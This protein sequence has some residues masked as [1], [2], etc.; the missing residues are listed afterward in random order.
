MRKWIVY[1]V[2]AALIL[3]GGGWLIMQRQPASSAGSDQPTETAVVQRGALAVTVE[4][5]GSLLPSTEITLAFPMG[6]KV[7]KVLV[8][9]G[10]MVEAGDLLVRLDDAALRK[11]LE[12]AELDLQSLTSPYAIADA[13]KAL[14]SAQDALEDAK[15]TNRVQQEG[16]RG[17]ASTIDGLKAELILANDNVEKKQ[18][19]FDHFADRDKDDYQRA[20]AQ[21]DL[22]AAIDARDAILRQLNWYLGHPSELDQAI[23]DADVAVAEAKVAAAKTLLAELN[24]E[25]V[26]QDE[27]LYLD[28]ALTRLQEAK[29]SVDNAKLAIADA[30]LVAPSGG[31]I[32]SL[33]VG[34]G[35]Y[36][37]PGQPVIVLSEVDDLQ[38]EINLDETD[39]ARIAIGS[40]VAITID[41]F[42]GAEL[43]GEVID[44][45]PS[46]TVQS[47]VVLYP[48]TVR[49]DPTDPS[50]GSGQALPLRPG[51]TANVTI[52]VEKREN[53]LFVP[54]RA[55]E[56][57][58]GQAYVTLKTE[59]GNLRVPVTLGLITDTQIEILSGVSEG[60]VVAVY[61][62]P[63]QD[64]SLQMQSPF[65][66]GQ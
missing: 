32:S 27:D 15:Y 53:T 65:S 46:A 17:S 7:A 19:V 18:V 61:A 42:P 41:A 38:A 29:I 26:P 8:V 52:T 39:V 56:T 16:N 25:P 50:T 44:I 49:L 43:A 37:S 33:E 24:G 47:G 35:E 2:I 66:G 36:V 58:G 9:R 30:Y 55:V 63:V 14:A 6:G 23:L 22:S 54:F 11:K 21:A 5:S 59:A 13:E 28:P 3:G 10:Q 57:E 62:N 4:A 31:M 51:M 45:A 40:P 60:D 34:V 20:V 48:V 1:I 64:S 12:Q